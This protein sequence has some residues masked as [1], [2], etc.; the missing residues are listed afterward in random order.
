[1]KNRINLLF[2]LAILF[3]GLL[4]SCAVNKNTKPILYNNSNYLNN[5]SQIDSINSSIIDGFGYT[6]GMYLLN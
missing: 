6:K 1:M 2:V 4:T 3:V 5:Y